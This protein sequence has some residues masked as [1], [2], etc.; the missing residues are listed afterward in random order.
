MLPYL[1]SKWKGRACQQYQAMDTTG[2]Q[3]MMGEDI[4]EDDEQHGDWD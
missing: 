1:A 4:Y 3:D 2:M